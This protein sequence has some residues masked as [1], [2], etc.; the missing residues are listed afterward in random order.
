MGVDLNEDKVHLLHHGQRKDR[1][2]YTLGEEGPRIEEVDQEKDLGVIIS[3]DLKPDKMI[4][5]QVQKAHMKISQFN[6]TFT[7]RGKT[8]LKM[9]KTYIKPSLLYACEAWRPSTLEGVE[10]L[11]GVQRRV[12]R[13]A[14]GQGVDYREA[15]RKAGLN[16]IQEELDEADIVRTFR[17]MNGHDKVDKK[18]FWK[19]EEP[20]PGAGRRRFRKQEVKRTIADQRKA[21]R[22]NSFASRVQDPWNKLEDCVKFCKTPMAFRK[23][24]RKLKNLV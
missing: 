10:K 8:W 4:A 12:I 1:R 22:K 3:S 15:C 6:A 24:Y 18:L 20:R 17:I 14:G 7:Y 9:Y 2:S 21:I 19:M 16:T 13:M 23:A 11:E 5:R